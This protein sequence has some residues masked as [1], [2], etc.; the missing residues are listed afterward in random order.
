MRK[1]LSAVALPLI[2]SD[3]FSCKLVARSLHTIS[4]SKLVLD[5]AGFYSCFL[6]C[7]C[8]AVNRSHPHV[9]SLDTDARTHLTYTLR[10]NR[11]RIVYIYKTVY[12]YNVD[13]LC[14]FERYKSMN[15]AQRS[16]STWLVPSAF[17]SFQKR[18]WGGCLCARFTCWCW[19]RVFKVS[20]SRSVVELWLVSRVVS[21]RSVCVCELYIVAYCVLSGY[22]W[23]LLVLEFLRYLS[24]KD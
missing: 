19:R 15:L 20:H 16:K 3:S 8:V 1:T 5:I 9:R 18:C 13:A 24:P 21:A 11:N 4:P 23:D 17:C 7:E 14:W 2:H 22:S 12:V 10:V 6:Q